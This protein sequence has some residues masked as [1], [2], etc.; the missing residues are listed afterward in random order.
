VIAK[1]TKLLTLAGAVALSVS[2]G[3]FVRQGRAPVLL[4]VKSL[5]AAS[6][7]DPGSLSGT[8]QS[9]VLVLRTSPDPCSPTSPCPTIVSDPGSVVIGLQLK[10]QGSLNVLAT[11]SLTNQVTINRYRVE[12]RRTD[13]RKQEGVDVPYSFD[14]AVT[15]SILADTDGASNFQLVRQS[16]KAEAPLRALSQSGN[17]ISTIATVTF[18]GHDQ[19]GNEVSVSSNIGIDFADFA[20]PD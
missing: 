5:Q 8:L 6:G 10:D 13:G 16:A 18:Y 2:C 4:L 7:A 9:D 1:F 14:S 12:Y 11:P 3:D 19:A 17:I 15:F 20:D